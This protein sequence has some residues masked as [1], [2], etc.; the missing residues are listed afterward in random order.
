MEGWAPLSDCA[1]EFVGLA[2][3]LRDRERHSVRET[4]RETE[5][6]REIEKQMRTALPRRAPAVRL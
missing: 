2:E 6:D 4:E 3:A 5:R 1:D